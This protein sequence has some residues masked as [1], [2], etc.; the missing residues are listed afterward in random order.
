MKKLKGLTRKGNCIT[1][2]CNNRRETNWIL[3]HI[4]RELGMFRMF[5]GSQWSKEQIA[6]MIKGKSSAQPTT[7]AAQN[8][9]GRVELCL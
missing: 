1:I 9:A 7:A 5:S 4:D 8:T 6:A 3:E 2:R